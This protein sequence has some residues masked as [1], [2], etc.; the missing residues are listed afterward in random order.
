MVYIAGG[1]TEMDL[2][3]GYMNTLR[4]WGISITHDWIATIR[5]VGDANPRVASH[6][7]R[8]QWSAQ[9]VRGVMDAQIVWAILP[10][11][12]SFGCAFEAG[13]A[14]GSGRDLI[15]SGDWRSTIF[16]AQARARFN[17]HDHALKWL[18]WHVTPGDWRD[19]MAELEA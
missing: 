12:T 6:R 3:A 1:S 14:I 16:S 15:V 11:K 9:D 5:T 4:A 13:V 8:F 19:E 10:A 18:R 7:K 17:E 2:V